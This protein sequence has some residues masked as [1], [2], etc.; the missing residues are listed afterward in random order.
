MPAATIIRALVEPA[1]RIVAHE[2]FNTPRQEVKQMIW[3][4]CLIKL[5]AHLII[6]SAAILVL[7]PPE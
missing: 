7:F 6:K 2:G 4:L 1:V 3:P 5:V